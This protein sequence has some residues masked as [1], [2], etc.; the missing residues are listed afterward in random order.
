MTHKYNEPQKQVNWCKI[1]KRLSTHT[2]NNQ[3]M[4]AT[5]KNMIDVTNIN[6]KNNN[7]TSRLNTKFLQQLCSRNDANSLPYVYPSV[8]SWT[9]TIVVISD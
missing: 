7:A 8:L 1:D 3:I 2:V 4:T 9:D 5:T 6:N